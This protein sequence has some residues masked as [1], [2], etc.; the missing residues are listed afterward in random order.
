MRN[1]FLLKLPHHPEAF[2]RARMIPVDDD[3]LE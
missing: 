2:T 1:A 3:Y